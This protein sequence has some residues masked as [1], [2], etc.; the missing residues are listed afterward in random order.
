M[1]KRQKVQN[2]I[3]RY[4]KYTSGIDPN[5]SFGCGELIAV[6]DEADGRIIDL[7]YTA[8]MYGF[9]RGYERALKDKE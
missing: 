6:R 7:I 8:M 2:S 4:H 9:T 5:R 1:E 3:A